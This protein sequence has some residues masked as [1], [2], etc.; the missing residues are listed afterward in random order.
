MFKLPE[1]PYPYESMSPIISADTF[2]AHHDKHHAKY[3]DTMN[4]LLE[5]RPEANGPLEAVVRAAAANG[6]GKL[7]NNAAQ[8]WNHAFFWD[9][10]TPGGGQPSDGLRD[11]ADR[12]FGG[13]DTLRERFVAEGV[14]HFASGWAWLVARN[15]AL[16]ILSTHDAGSFDQ[17]HGATPLIVCDVWEHAYYLDHK[18]DRKGFLEQWFDGV[19]DW[20]F[21]ERQLR[22]AQGEGAAWTFPVSA[23]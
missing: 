11:A 15:G 17:F 1:L 8:S 5:G 22:A 14:N 18:Q 20:S 6:E 10:M 9:A 23:S 21:A 2:H 16:E 3:V 7:Y 19:A 12:A 4:S 13:W